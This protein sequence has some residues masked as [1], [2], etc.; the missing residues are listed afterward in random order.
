MEEEKMILN[1]GQ[2]DEQYDL[3]IKTHQISVSADV[4]ADKGW[5][6]LADDEL[7]VK[8]AVLSKEETE[9]FEK[10]KV[11]P[12]FDDGSDNFSRKVFDKSIEYL[13]DWD[14]QSDFL[15]RLSQAYFT[16]YTIKEKKY[17]IKLE[18][19]RPDMSY[20][21]INEFGVW[22]LSSKHEL[23]D[24]KTQFTQ[25]EIDEMQKY[26]RAKGLDLNVLKVEVPDDELE[27]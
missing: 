26:S 2:Y 3:E 19:N 17:Y 12:F 20:L 25:A 8:K 24:T 14:K 15:N 6:K 7:V 9:W 5:Y 11:L 13:E 10:Y 22:F 4:L 1:D 18:F 23:A 21:N 27:D 16:G